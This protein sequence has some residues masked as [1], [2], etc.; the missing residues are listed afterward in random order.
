MAADHDLF[1]ARLCRQPLEVD[2]PD[3]GDVL[4]VVVVVVHHDVGGLGR[5]VLGEQRQVLVEAGRVLGEVEGHVASVCLEVLQATVV[6]SEG[7]EGP[8]KSELVDAGKTRR[9]VG[10]QHVVGHVDATESRA[11]INVVAPVAD[12][13]RHATV[14][15]ANISRD[16]IELRPREVTVRASE[17]TELRIA[18]VVVDELGSAHLAEARLGYPVRLQPEVLAHAE[19][20]HL[21]T[22]FGRPHRHAHAQR[23]VSAGDERRVG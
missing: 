7:I 15:H 16:E 18:S 21:R 17:S 14:C 8:L 20:E 19:R 11:E 22:R 9:G 3:P 12:I 10:S 4:A 23:I 2:V 13:E 5:R 6:W 1:D